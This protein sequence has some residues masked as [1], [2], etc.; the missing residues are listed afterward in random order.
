LSPIISPARSARIFLVQQRLRQDG[1]VG[2]ALDVDAFTAFVADEIAR[3]KPV[4]ERAGL[5]G[6]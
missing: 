5:A 2:Q 6:K 1:L 3:W 4:V